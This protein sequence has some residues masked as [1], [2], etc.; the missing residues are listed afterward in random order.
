MSTSFPSQL[1]P[2][3]LLK[4]YPDFHIRLKRGGRK[5]NLKQGKSPGKGSMALRGCI[6]HP[7]E[8]GQ[9]EKDF[10]SLLRFLIE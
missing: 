9:N 3:V 6:G 5:S 1:S 8:V 4:G 10:A 2:W 7:N